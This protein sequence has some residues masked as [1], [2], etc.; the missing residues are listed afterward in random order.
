MVIT[1]LVQLVDFCRRRAVAVLLIAL[2]LALA[3]IAYTAGHLSFDTNTANLIDPTVPWR[4]REIAL[5]RAFPQ[6]VDRLAVVIDGRTPDQ[7]EDASDALGTRPAA[8]PGLFK[9]VR[10]PGAGDFFKKNG[11]LVLPVEEVQDTTH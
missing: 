6:N 8:L 4:Q 2:A 11:L 7:A 10:Q 3:C 9:S 5:D 1:S